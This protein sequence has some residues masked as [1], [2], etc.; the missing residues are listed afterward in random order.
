MILPLNV[1]RKNMLSERP[2]KIILVGD[3]AVGK[4]SIVNAFTNVRFSEHY[5]MTIGATFASKTVYVAG[6]EVRLSIWDL[7][8]QPRFHE[9]S[10]LFLKGAQAALYVF[11]V[12]RPYTLDNLINWHRR[13]IEEAGDIPRVIA[14]N[15]IDIGSY[16]GKIHEEAKTFASSVG[17]IYIPTSAKTGQNIRESFATLLSLLYKTKDIKV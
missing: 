17:G 6:K 4:T 13:V 14:G 3:G 16:S 9:I 10:Q 8:G 15:K 1:E 11:D 7:A 5:K 12:T 2:V